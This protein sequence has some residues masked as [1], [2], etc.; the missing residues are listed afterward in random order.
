MSA[1]GGGSRHQGFLDLF[2]E[3][4]PFAAFSLVLLTTLLPRAK[5][6][7]HLTAFVA[8]VCLLGSGVLLCF[9]PDIGFP[10]T[11]YFSLWFV[12][13]FGVKDKLDE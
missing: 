6:L 10:L 8:G 1:F 5:E 7:L 13:Y 2:T 3:Y 4:F 9:N 11:A 12:Y